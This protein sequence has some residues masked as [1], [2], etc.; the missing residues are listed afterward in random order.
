M[1]SFQVGQAT[2]FMLDTPQQS[3]SLLSEDM[4]VVIPPIRPDDFL[5]GPGQHLGWDL[6][7]GFV[8]ATADSLF[9][10]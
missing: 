1:T 3:S 4:L 10:F 2:G 7:E 8:D 9:I 6:L 5:I